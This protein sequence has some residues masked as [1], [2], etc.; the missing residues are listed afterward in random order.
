M[1]RISV[2]VLLVALELLN[3][4]FPLASTAMANGSLSDASLPKSMAEK[5]SAP[6]DALT[7]V[8]ELPK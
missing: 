8:V 6:V 1:P 2:R 5:V 4:R 7:A 3:Q